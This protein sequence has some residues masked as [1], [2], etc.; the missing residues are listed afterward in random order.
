[1]MNA[2]AR[3][4]HSP[5]A[6]EAPTRNAPQDVTGLLTLWS[7][8]DAQAGERLLDI[9]YADLHAMAQRFVHGERQDL[10]L[11]PTALV[12]EAYLR[13]VD[14]DRATWQNRSH[15]FAIAA[16]MMRRVLVDHARGRLAIKRGGDR[17]KVPLEQV[18]QL[19]GGDPAYLLALDDALHQLAAIDPQKARIV[20]LRFF[21]GFQFQEIARLLRISTAT[22]NRHWRIARGWLYSNIHSDP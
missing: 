2:L 8:G 11:Q 22:L 3:E 9:I 20:E 14:Q 15:F 7:A 13:L 19:F 10:T 18:D 21:G 6:H 5:E 4:H 16:Q 1:M 17:V 12:H